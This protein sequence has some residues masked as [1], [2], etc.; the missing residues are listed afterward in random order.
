M[1]NQKTPEDKLKD[2]LEDVHGI[3]VLDVRKAEMTLKIHKHKGIDN[4]T[5]D[6]CIQL[7]KE[8][9]EIL[10][11]MTVMDPAWE[12]I[13]EQRNSMLKHAEALNNYNALGRH[14]HQFPIHAL[15]NVK[16]ISVECTFYI[17]QLYYFPH[18]RNKTIL[19]A[20]RNKI[21]SL[22]EWSG[23]FRDPAVI[24]FVEL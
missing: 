2:I 22:P 21:C 4:L 24:D 17:P 13:A 12:F 5:Y 11:H 16:D 18:E 7:V 14:E 1:N 10:E 19:S 15:V 6:E 8:N 9:N 20:L 3:P 23:S